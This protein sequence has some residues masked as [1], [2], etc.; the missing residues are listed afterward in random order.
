MKRELSVKE[1]LYKFGYCLIIGGAIRGFLSI[2][3]LRLRCYR[4]VYLA[5]LYGEKIDFCLIHN[6]SNRKDRIY[7]GWQ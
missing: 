3:W 7:S 4:S 6:I 5:D 2:N 1:T